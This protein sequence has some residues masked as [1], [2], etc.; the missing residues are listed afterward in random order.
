VPAVNSPLTQPSFYDLQ[1]A[2]ITG[3]SISLERYRGQV[4]L[5]VNVAS[6]CVF[7]SQYQGLQE[8][9][10]TY[11]EQGFVVLGFPCNQFANQE[12]KSDAEIASFCSLQ[13]HVTFPMFHKVEVNGK[14][15]HPLFAFLKGQAK[16]WFSSESI[17]WNFTKFLVDRSGNVVGRFSPSTTPNQL[18][19]A[20]EKCLNASSST[21]TS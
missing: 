13:F 18:R 3:E 17:K 10:D 2:T 21:R 20:I 7:T 9:Y 19:Q 16:G 6:R 11:R 15:T 4:L 5:I 1:A 8:L 14:K 12:P